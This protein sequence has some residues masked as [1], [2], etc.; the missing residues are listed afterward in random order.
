MLMM[1]GVV[2]IVQEGRFQLLDDEGVSHHFLLKHSAAADPEQLPALL[3]RRICVSYT[4]PTNLIGH[5]AQ[6]VLLLETA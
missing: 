6:Q 5:A 2:T 3:R 1:T 4:D